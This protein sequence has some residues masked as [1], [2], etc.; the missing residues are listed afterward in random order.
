MRR[1]L[2][3]I[4]SPSPATDTLH[5]P[6]LNEPI[7]RL[8]YCGEKNARGCRDVTRTRFSNLR[9]IFQDLTLF[10][11]ERIVMRAICDERE[12]FSRLFFHDRKKEVEPRRDRFLFSFWFV[13]SSECPLGGAQSEIILV[14]A[15]FDD[16]FV[17]D[18]LDERIPCSKQEEIRENTLKAPITVFK[19]MNF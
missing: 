8:A 18:V 2:S 17:R 5:L 11:G 1:L 10:E 7:E 13:L 14:L 15:L 9:E 12:R 19:R 6:D 16:L 3:A 4:S